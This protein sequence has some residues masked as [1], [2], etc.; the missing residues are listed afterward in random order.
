MNEKD[1][2]RR[3][4]KKKDIKPGVFFLYDSYLTK[5]VVF[6]ITSHLRELRGSGLN[7]EFDFIRLN[8]THNRN[9]F[10]FYPYTF[11]YIGG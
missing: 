6:M 1:Q 4:L 5:D 8:K 11:I 2:I 9:R 10:I 3:Y 7:S